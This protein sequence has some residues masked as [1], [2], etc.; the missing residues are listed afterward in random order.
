MSFHTTIED[1][2]IKTCYRVISLAN[3]NFTGKFLLQHILPNSNVDNIKEF[4]GENNA[5]TIYFLNL[6]KQHNNKHY[7]III[8][9]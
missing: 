6:R 8:Q 7:N 5:H 4:N 9:Y 2:I 1:V 3:S